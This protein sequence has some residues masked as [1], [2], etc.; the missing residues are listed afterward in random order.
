MGRETQRDPGGIKVLPIYVER[1][2]V[3]LIILPTTSR[4][5]PPVLQ[6]HNLQQLLPIHPDRVPLVKALD[7]V[8]RRHE[9][10]IKYAAIGTVAI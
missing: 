8:A 3:T 4:A 1:W 10:V 2:S 7:V 9:R 6:L 5:H